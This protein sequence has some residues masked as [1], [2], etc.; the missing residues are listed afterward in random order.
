MRR[1]SRLKL[2]R[3]F[4]KIYREGRSVVSPEVVLYYL[5]RETPE[6]SRMGLVVSR[7]LGKAAARNKV[8]RL[9]RESYRRNEMRIG[10]G[11]DLC[12]IARRPL[13]EKSFQEVEKIFLTALLKAGLLK[14]EG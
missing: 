11:H 6:G 2:A 12:V 4:E 5:K 13:K 1:P 10:P 14:E 7:A 9:L 3:D 8:K